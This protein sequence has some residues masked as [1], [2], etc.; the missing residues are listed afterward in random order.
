MEY[1][2]IVLA[3]G[4]GTRL[5]LGYNKL[6][7]EIRDNWTIIQETIKLFLEDIKCSQLLLV[8][9]E[10]DMVNIKSMFVHDKVEYIIGGARR[11]DSVS[12]G[13]KHVKNPY[14]LI[15]DG[16][17]PYLKQSSVDNLLKALRDNDA[18]ILAV[19]MKD[20]VK[21]VKNGYVINTPKRSELVAAQT[22]QGFLTTAIQD[23]Y[24][25]MEQLQIEV[26]DDASVI[27]LCTN[28]PV[29]IIEGY[30]DN[31][32]ITTKEDLNRN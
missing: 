4:S 16:A 2:A 5:A 21:Q 17:R 18:C 26:S 11:Q 1:T 13:L 32:K 14:V 8:C 29:K 31:I 23:A 19:P 12:A 3:A 9:N 27:E 24:A 15:H 30:Y 25:R 20:T 10:V 7:Y 22:P 28:I 6:L